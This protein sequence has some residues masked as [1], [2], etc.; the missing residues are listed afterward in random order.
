[1]LHLSGQDDELGGLPPL[2]N[3]DLGDPERKLSWKEKRQM[4]RA[5]IDSRYDDNVYTRSSADTGNATFSERLKSTTKRKSTTGTR[6]TQIDVNNNISGPGD[7]VTASGSRLMPFGE[8]GDYWAGMPEVIPEEELIELPPMPDFRTPDQV[9]RKERMRNLRVAKYEAR[10]AEAEAKRERKEL[11]RAAT[12]NRPAADPSSALVQVQSQGGGQAIYM[13]NEAAP[14]TVGNGTLKP[15]NADSAY[16]RNNQQV[17]QGDNPQNPVKFWWQRG[18][19]EQGGREPD[20]S[21][22]TWRNPLKAASDDVQTVSYASS[23]DPGGFSASTSAL[24]ATPLTSNL[25]GIRIVKAT[26]E[27]SPSGLGGISGVV[28]EGVDLPPR[29]LAVFESRIGSN[30][31]LGDLNQMVRDAV[32]AYRRSDLP[33]VDVLV[34]EQEITTGVLQL[35]VIE[36]RLGDVLVEGTSEREGRSLARQIRTERGEVIRESRLTEDLAW[37]NKHPTRQV[38]LIFSPGTNYGETDVILRSET[39]KAL[40]AFIAYENSGTSA[41]G[42]SRAI[43]G[44]SWTGPLFTGQDSILSYQ[45][46]TNFD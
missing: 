16:F 7:A 40:S 44:A 34:P 8:E 33:V 42:E 25:R 13:G 37:I 39:Y 1:M 31:T 28:T 3:L 36:G 30:L 43:F 38:D 22:F 10:K 6:A 45:F 15:F 35:V 4:N 21:K 14:E 27:V 29:V 17:Y 46:T 32:L 20:E 26:R 9:T 5:A 11:E 2:P 18:T 24:E 19:S 12:V 41:L 23:A